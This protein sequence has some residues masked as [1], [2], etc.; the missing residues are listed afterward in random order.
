MADNVFGAGFERGF[1]Q[2]VFVGIGEDQIALVDEVEGDAAVGAEIA[3]VFG[4]GVAH[5]GNGAGFVVGHAIDHQRRAADAVAFV[6]QLD[7]VHAFE[8]TGAFVDGALDVVFGHIGVPSFVH[9]QPQAGVGCGIA[10][11]QA[12]GDGDFF[13]QSGENFAAFGVGTGL[14]VLDVRPLAVSGHEYSFM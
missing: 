13:N 12:G 1:H 10:A 8:I 9:C 2:R 3:A 14:F 4:K 11:A 5:V 7:V 6:A